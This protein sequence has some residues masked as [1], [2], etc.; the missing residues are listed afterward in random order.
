[1]DVAAIQTEI[2]TN[3]PVEAAFTVY[4]DFNHYRSGVYRHTAG[5]LVGGHAVKIIGWGIQNGAPYWLMA[6][7]WGPYWGENGFFKMLR[8]VD[9]CGI[10]STIVAG[11]PDCGCN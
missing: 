5:K 10:E 3:G 7:S 1:M 8:G 6:N 2:M 11:K 4:D 9:E